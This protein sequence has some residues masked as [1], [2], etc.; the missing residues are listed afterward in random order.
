[1]EYVQAGG[2]VSYGA[3][4]PAHRRRAAYYVNKILRGSKPS[5]L[6]VEQPKHLE[7]AVNVTTAKAL[8]LNLPPGLIILAD[9]LIE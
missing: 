6:P 1:M 2:L 7:L 9:H 8:G 5:D 4:L 3:S